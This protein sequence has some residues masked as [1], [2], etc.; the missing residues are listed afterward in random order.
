MHEYVYV[1]VRVC[2]SVCVCVCV[3][4]CV[5]CVVSYLLQRFRLVRAIQTR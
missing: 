2:M 4:V 1:Y 3:C 5:F